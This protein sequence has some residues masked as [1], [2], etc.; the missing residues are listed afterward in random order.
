MKKV[1]MNILNPFEV[2]CVI[3]PPW[4]MQ[5][6]MVLHEHHGVSSIYPNNKK[7]KNYM[8]QFDYV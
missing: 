7:K 2:L 1:N 5:L 3:W 6:N 8:V 4:L